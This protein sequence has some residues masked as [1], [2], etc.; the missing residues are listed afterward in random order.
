MA[1]NWTKLWENLSRFFDWTFAGG[2]IFEAVMWMLAVIFGDNKLGAK[3]LVKWT[4]FA[5]YILFA[6]FMTFVAM[7]NKRI[8]HYCG[9]LKGIFAKTCFYW[10]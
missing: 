1:I 4:V 8:F 10:L 5:Y 2:F 6:I 7:K 3:V 9:F